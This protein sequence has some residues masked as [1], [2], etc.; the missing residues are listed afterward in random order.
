MVSN[1]P[2]YSG[3]DISK[4]VRRDLVTPLMIL[5]VVLVGM[6]L[7]Y[8]WTTLTTLALLYLCSIPFALNS[9]N[10]ANIAHKQALASAEKTKG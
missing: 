5:V 9:W 2:T 4:K 6:L 7:T 8:P 3:K 10:K 1:L